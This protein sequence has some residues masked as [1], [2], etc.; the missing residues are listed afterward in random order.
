MTFR[1]FYLGTT[2][3]VYP[4][5]IEGITEINKRIIPI[6]SDSSPCYPPV[7]IFYRLM[8]IPKAYKSLSPYNMLFTLTDISDRFETFLKNW[9]DKADL[10]EP[11]Y[12]L[13]FGILYNPPTNPRPRFLS[14]IQA[15]ESFHRRKF[16]GQYLKKEDYNK[17]YEVLTKAIP[18]DV[19]CDLKE[20]L[21]EYLK[22]GN[23]FSLRKR[24]KGIFKEYQ[25]I[26]NKFIENQNAFIELVINTR[27][28]L[29]HH[30]EELRES[31]ANSKEITSLTERL[32]MLAEICLLTE[33]E[34][35]SE[36]I[37]GFFLR[38]NIFT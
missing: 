13:Y 4:L 8:N 15:V 2:E 25:E 9:F 34:F 1:V 17:I 18:D 5:A 14:L 12:N 35:S 23:E 33:L 28:Y 3:P 27:N 22:Y 11:F 29:T 20:R 37:K 31:A 32:K 6:N 16:G 19:V 7:K 10:L 21:K 38:K 24:L 30:D 26:L 36:E